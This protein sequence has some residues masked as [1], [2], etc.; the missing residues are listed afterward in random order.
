[1]QC[2]AI[3]NLDPQTMGQLQ[4]PQTPF[5]RVPGAEYHLN[6]EFLQNE[7]EGML[8]AGTQIAFHQ[9]PLQ[10]EG[11]VP[12]SPEVEAIP[13]V[14]GTHPDVSSGERWDDAHDAHVRAVALNHVFGHAAPL[15][16]A[17]FA[18]KHR[19]N[20]G[21]MGSILKFCADNSRPPMVEEHF[22]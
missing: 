9:F 8:S 18:V 1:M 2:P 16:R 14:F 17:A 22:V 3:P 19:H 21:G 11:E 5:N 6:L 13:E 20:L 15:I 7:D 4:V 12:P 10:A